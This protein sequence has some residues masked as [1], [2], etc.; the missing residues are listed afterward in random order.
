MTPLILTDKQHAGSLDARRERRTSTTWIAAAVPN[1]LWGR[2]CLILSTETS[3]ISGAGPYK[4]PKR[5]CVCCKL[6]GKDDDDLQL[7]LWQHGSR[8]IKSAGHSFNK[9]LLD[10]F[11]P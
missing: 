8:Y 4:L 6:K 7:E 3:Y 1:P 5:A 10:K 2:A 11:M 9:A